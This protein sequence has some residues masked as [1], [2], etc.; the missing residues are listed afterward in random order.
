MIYVNLYYT[1]HDYKN[2]VF[3][4]S[5]SEI[6]DYN[7]IINKLTKNDVFK[8]IPSNTVVSFYI[9]KRLRKIFEDKDEHRILYV[10]KSLSP[11]T[12]KNISYTLNSLSREN[13]KIFHLDLTIK[14]QIS[15]NLGEY[16]KHVE[17]IHLL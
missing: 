4:T 15:I 14:D 16:K 7:L 6:I 3:D 5:Y 8:L 12:I 9:L 13:K 2:E 10:I 11:E 17:Q 1:K